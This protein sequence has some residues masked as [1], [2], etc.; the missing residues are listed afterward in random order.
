MEDTIKR[1]FKEFYQANV[2]LEL[3]KLVDLFAIFGGSQIPFEID[4][5]DSIEEII[6]F[7]FVENF[8]E[9]EDSIS[10]SYL[11]EKPYSR[12]LTAVAR[13]DGRVTNAF[14]RSRI[15]DGI[16]WKLIRE[17]EELNIIFLEISREKPL[18]TSKN[19]KLPK[20]LRGYHIEPKIRFVTPFMRFW[21]AFVAPFSKDLTHK[22][23]SAF[24]ENFELH[25]TRLTGLL[26]EQLSIAMLNQ[27][28]GNTLLSNGSYWDR[29]FN[30][31]DVYAITKHSKSIV[32]ECKYKNKKICKNEL[33]KL[34]EKAKVSILSPEIY[35][36][37]SKSG[38]SNELKS[39]K[40]DKLLLF[41]LEDLVSLIV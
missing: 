36:L 29:H 10:P 26:F 5:T 39:M 3:D 2:H 31:F 24:Y 20:D 22:Q 11:L 34:Q 14:N 16:G 30:E 4:K 1:L 23:S 8:Q 25:F 9:I 6:R 18:L 12:F 33:S 32:G 17:L 35:A 41:E 37:F 40:S 7:H 21:F 38:F 27:H 15:G 28:F 13:G 19:Q